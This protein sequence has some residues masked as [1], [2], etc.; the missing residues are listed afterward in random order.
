MAGAVAAR[1]YYASLDALRLAAFGVI[2]AA[3]AAGT[4]AALL[5]SQPEL[6]RFT[7]G[8]LA[9]GNAAAQFF[10][11]LSGFL[12]IGQLTADRAT[13]ALAIGAFWQRR[14]RRLLPLYGVCL[15]IGFGLEP[16]LAHLMG[17]AG[18][19]P[20][21][22]SRYLL[23][24]SN[25]DKLRTQPASWVLAELW[26]IAVEAQFYVIA[27]LLIALTPRR[28]LPVVL[29]GVLAA[30]GVFQ[31]LHRTEGIVLKLHTAAIATDFAVGGLAAL[32]LLR[33][34]P[35]GAATGLGLRYGAGALIAAVVVAR[36]TVLLSAEVAPF[37]RLLVSTGIAVAL[38]VA[39][40]ADTSAPPGGAV[41]LAA[42]LGR[43]TYGL[44]CLHTA[45]LGLVAFAASRVSLPPAAV[46][47]G[48]P[49]VALLLTFGLA[50]T[51]YQ[52][53]ERPLNPKI[54]RD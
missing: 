21:R 28:W 41:Q 40:R 33:L 38:V 54:N 12:I 44:Y 42:R 47:A 53:L 19:E 2:F 15:L 7:P 37:L 34:R 5:P 22:L 4:V 20:G 13:G 10:F 18:T 9:A 32:A 8:L 43:R 3:H 11:T 29:G 24:L 51:S 48:G 26:A 6:A 50:E 1:P 17:A 45:A 23:M 31:W 52:W 16:L 49:L 39:A 25:F 27:P 36:A 30:S 14:A 46:V 35:T